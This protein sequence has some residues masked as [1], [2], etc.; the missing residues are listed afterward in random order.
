M[1]ICAFYVSKKQRVIEEKDVRKA[2]EGM[3]K[4]GV[5]ALTIAQ[6]TPLLMTLIGEP[7]VAHASDLVYMGTNQGGI[8]KSVDELI[9]RAEEI[10]Y[11]LQRIA[12]PAAYGFAIKGVLEKMSGQDSLGSKH[13]KEALKGYV[14]IQLLPTLFDLIDVFR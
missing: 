11:A 13:I 2:I 7:M 4:I 9:D 1:K 14:L 5:S 8:A 10:I 12:Y 3:A 6:L